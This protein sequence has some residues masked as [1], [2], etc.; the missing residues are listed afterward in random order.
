MLLSLIYE[1]QLK[2]MSNENQDI[3]IGSLWVKTVGEGGKTVITGIIN[4][5]RVKLVKNTNKTDEKKPSYFVFQIKGQDD[6]EISF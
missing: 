1:G 2:I 5:K 4:N 3:L 6:A